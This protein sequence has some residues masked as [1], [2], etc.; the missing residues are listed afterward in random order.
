MIEENN[1]ENDAI[2]NVILENNDEEYKKILVIINPN[3]G[4]GNTEDIFLTKIKPYF[5]QHSKHKIDS[6]I[7]KYPSHIEYYI[8]NN[9]HNLK[10][11]NSIIVL[12]GDGTVSMTLNSLI[13]NQMEIPLGIIPAGSGNG[14]M[15]SIFYERCKETYNKVDCYKLAEE[16]TIKKVDTISVSSM[17]GQLTSL[18]AISWGIISDL[19]I[20][21]EFLRCLGNFRFDLGAIWGILRK[22]KYVGTLSYKNEEGEYIKITDNFL[23]FWACNSAYASETTKS[24]PNSMF[25]DGYIYISYVLGGVSRIELAKIM[26]GLAD[27]KFIEH[28]SV[29]YIKTTNFRLEIDNGMVVVDG[30]RTNF[31]NINCDIQPSSYPLVC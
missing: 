17:T 18:L 30:E 21:T 29:H 22:N 6:W 31:K 20:N 5:A 27:G 25:S 3:S 15:R 10:K 19:D 13:K 4:R 14:L 12:G 1:I 7:S 8:Q 11:Y 16:Q 26:L 28:P 24:S 9:K 23:H 2:K